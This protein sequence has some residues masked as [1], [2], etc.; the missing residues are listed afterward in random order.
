MSIAGADALLAVCQD[1]VAPVSTALKAEAKCDA[2]K[3]LSSS[4]ADAAFWT[5]SADNAVPPPQHHTRTVAVLVTPSA[6]GVE[7]ETES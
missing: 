5:V 4:A 3:T 7:I 1:A 6:D 2:R